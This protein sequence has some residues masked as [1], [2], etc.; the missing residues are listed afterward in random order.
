M[1]S[2]FSSIRRVSA[3]VSLA[4]LCFSTFI[5]I[6]AVLVSSFSTWLL[7]LGCTFKH[8]ILSIFLICFGLPDALQAL[9]I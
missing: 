6:V 5:L 2:F 8:D 1:G 9:Q 7:I 4:G 3:A